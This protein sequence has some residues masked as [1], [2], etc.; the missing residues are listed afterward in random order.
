VAGGSFFEDLNTTQHEYLR[1]HLAPT[2]NIYF[3]DSSR[4]V[5]STYSS[6]EVACASAPIGN[7][8]LT[9]ECL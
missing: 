4:G 5:G 9:R 7:G 8:R 3:E 6:S 2:V 1:L